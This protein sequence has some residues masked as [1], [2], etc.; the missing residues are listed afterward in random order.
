MIFDFAFVAAAL[1]GCCSFALCVLILYRLEQQVTVIKQNTSLPFTIAL[2]AAREGVAMFNADGEHVDVNASYVQLFGYDDRTQLLGKSWRSLYAPAQPP[3][4]FQDALTDLRR[5]LQWQG[6]VM[7]NRQDGSPFWVEVSLTPHADAFICVCRDITAAKQTHDRLHLL[8]RAIAASNAS[9][10]ITD[11]T[12]PDNPTIYANSGFEHLTGYRREEAI[13]RNCRFLQGTDVDQPALHQMEQAINQGIACTVTLRTY[14]KDSSCFWSDFALSPVRD[15]TGAL[16]H[17]VIVQTDVTEH[18]Q[19]EIDLARDK[20]IA[21]LATRA[22]S[23][24][25]ATMSHEIRTPMNAVIGLTDLLLDMQ[26]TSQQ[27]NFVKMIRNSSNTL[28]AII[29]DILDFS[30]IE[31]G[32]LELE[33]APFNL[34]T[35]LRESL[36]MVLPKATEKALEIAYVVDPQTPDFLIGDVTRLQ[37][38]LVNLLSNAVKFTPQGEIM[39]A[40]KA[41]PVSPRPMDHLSPK[42]ET[43]SDLYEVHVAVN[44]TGIGIPIERM[45]RLFK[46][47]SQVDCSTSRQYGGSGLG[48][49]ISKHLS[50]LMGGRIWVESH[51]ELG[52]NSPPDYIPRTAWM[53]PAPDQGATFY[54]TILAQS[55]PQPVSPLH[56]T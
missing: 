2:A 30:K 22:K 33:Q 40:V 50:E 13:G 17:Y 44:D 34:R 48:L 47:F 14:H 23:E 3:H 12:R 46:S 29:N 43:A 36:D 39:V 27:A 41:I 9:I 11:P 16:T 45:D 55:S 24:F 32:K 26:L 56:R 6:E 8:E 21:E 28:L 5:S 31:S 15:E 52:G 18:H 35:C 25:L 20:Q 51:G 7:A 49:A 4:F 53:S 10:L 1:L 42:A 38:I 37:Q 54:F 19:T